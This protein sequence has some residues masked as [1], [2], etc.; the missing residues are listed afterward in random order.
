MHILRMWRLKFS[1]RNCFYCLFSKQTTDGKEHGRQNN[2]RNNTALHKN[3]KRNLCE[4]RPLC[5]GCITP[6]KVMSS[7]TSHIKIHFYLRQKR[8]RLSH[9]CDVQPWPWSWCAF[10]LHQ[11][12][13][14]LFWLTL[15][16][17]V[18]HLQ[19]KFLCLLC[20]TT[21]AHCFRLQQ[22]KA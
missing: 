20:N 18:P 7:E 19:Q 9:S 17:S 2:V 5:T 13:R 12:H 1:E 6:Q 16:S 3:T 14:D 10:A 15:Y 8:F 11:P 4:N 22:W 21:F